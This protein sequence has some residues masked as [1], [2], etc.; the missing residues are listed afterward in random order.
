MKLEPLPSR[1]GSGAR[2]KDEVQK[3]EVATLLFFFFLRQD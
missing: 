1:T 2:T 3:D